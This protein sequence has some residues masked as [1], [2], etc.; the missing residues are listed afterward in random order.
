MSNITCKENTNIKFCKKCNIETSRNNR[1]D[2]KPCVRASSVAWRAANIDSYAAY[3]AAYR[4]ANSDKSRISNATWRAENPDKS[5]ANSAS[6]RASNADKEKAYKAAYQAANADKIKAKNST[7]YV[8]NSVKIKAR[9]AEWRKENPEILRINNQNR[10]AKELKAGG[11]L[12]K[13][14]F[15]KLF[16]LQRGKCP[17]CKTALSNTKPRSPM[18][19]I[20]ALANGGTNEDCNIQLL[21]QPCNNQKHIKDPIV[22]MQSRGFLL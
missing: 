10:R 11:K 15:D 7:Y 1:G 18:D 22:F 20:V 13:G 21:C 4:A 14:L 19:H 5:R 17:V 9:N 8:A 12:S 16:R 2:C 6:W 3:L